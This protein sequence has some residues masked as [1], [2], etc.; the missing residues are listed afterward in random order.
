MKQVT[1]LEGRKAKGCGGETG[2]ETKYSEKGRAVKDGARERRIKITEVMGN[3]E[4]E[5][6]SSATIRSSSALSQ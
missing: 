6:Y 5:E 4:E 1:K 2:A 3:P